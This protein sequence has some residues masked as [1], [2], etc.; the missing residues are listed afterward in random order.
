[1]I[2]SKEENFGKN[3]IS[4]NPRN[5]IQ[6][7][8]NLSVVLNFIQVSFQLKYHSNSNWLESSRS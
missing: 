3:K 1:M 4:Q 6:M 8:E 2:L 7:K 5:K